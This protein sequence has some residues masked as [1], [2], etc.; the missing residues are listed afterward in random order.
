M[1]K[2][3][4]QDG[5]SYHDTD[6]ERLALELETADLAHLEEDVLVECLHLSNHT[7]GE[8]LGDW[9]RA[10][11]FAEA[12]CSANPDCEGIATAQAHL[13]VSRYMDGALGSA[14]QAEVQ[15][16]GAAQDPVSASVVLKSLLATAMAGSGRL[17]E[18][19]LVIGAVN[20][21]A[22][23]SEGGQP[24]D[25]PLAIA[26][27][28][29]AGALYDMDDLDPAYNG[30][31]EACAAASLELWRR[32][33]TWINEERGLYLLALVN[34]R[35]RDYGRGVEYAVAALDVIGAH[36]GEGGEDVDE[37]FVRLA[38]AH[39]YAG[40]SDGGRSQEEVAKADALAS[41]WSDASLVEEYRQERLKAIGSS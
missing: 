17:D 8:H 32:C 2:D 3:L 26:N 40:L 34:N 27:N 33:G 36:S 9:S 25:R 31:M 28:N 30:L 12:A 20:E 22:L 13:A 39:A 6:S 19:G 11:R 37:C 16:I 41:E 14:Q 7:I 18:A 4:I 35:L 5:W 21:L 1:I 38:A 23:G 10:R 15:S 24:W 29:I